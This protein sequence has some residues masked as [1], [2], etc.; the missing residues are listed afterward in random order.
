MLNW[1]EVLNEIDALLAQQIELDQEKRDNDLITRLLQLS[2]VMLANSSA[3]KSVDVRA[4]HLA[5]FIF[6]LD[7]VLTLTIATKRS[8][9]F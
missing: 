7:L 4:F 8:S 2:E 3:Y 5:F 1:A 9:N 6:F